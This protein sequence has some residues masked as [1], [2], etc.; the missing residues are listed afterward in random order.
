MQGE[1]VIAYASRALTK[2]ER[3]YSVTKRELLAEVWAAQNFRSYLVGRRFVLRTDH[4]ALQWLFEMQDAEGQLARWQFLLRELTSRSFIAKVRSTATRT[5]CRDIH[6]LC[7]RTRS[8][9][10]GFVCRFLRTGHSGHP[11]VCV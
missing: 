9:T 7:R 8:G 6:T 4:A 11:S 2:A 3:Q 5:P 1:H 10:G